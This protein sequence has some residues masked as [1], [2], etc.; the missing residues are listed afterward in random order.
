MPPPTP[1]NP[2]VLA[3]TWAAFPNQPWLLAARPGAALLLAVLLATVLRLLP[4]AELLDPAL[5]EDDTVTIAV[6]VN[7]KLRGTITV[8]KAADK[9]ACESAALDLPAVQKQ[10]DGKPPKKVIIVPGKIVNIVAA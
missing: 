6:Q 1:L 5:L 2:I 8:A 7:G 3:S 10:L 4:E 9:A